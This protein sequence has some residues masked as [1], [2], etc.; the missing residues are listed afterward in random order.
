MTMSSCFHVFYFFFPERKNKTPIISPLSLFLL[1][2]RWSG[3][4]SIIGRGT[5]GYRPDQKYLDE[6]EIEWWYLESVGAGHSHG[7]LDFNEWKLASVDSLCRYIR[8]Q[9]PT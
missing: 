1:E 6:M 3:M 7:F 5:R 4:G 9:P 2:T 8:Y